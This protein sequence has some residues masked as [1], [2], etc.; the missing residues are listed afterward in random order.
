MRDYQVEIMSWLL[1]NYLKKRNSLIAN[2][3]ELGK[4]VQTVIFIDSLNK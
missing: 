1:S 3:V 4:T 2:D